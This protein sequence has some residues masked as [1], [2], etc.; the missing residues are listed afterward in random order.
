MIGVT[1]TAKAI[2][3]FVPNLIKLQ[4]PLEGPESVCYSF[5]TG[6]GN[7]LEQTHKG[8]ELL[9]EHVDQ[10]VPD[11]LSNI[12]FQTV[13]CSCCDGTDKTVSI[14]KINPSG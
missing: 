14:K 13:S 7:I 9:S 1:G 8:V 12:F 5:C 2:G 10:P 6:C 3:G 11:D 4:A